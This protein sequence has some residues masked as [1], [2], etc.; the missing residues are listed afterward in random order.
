ML[1]IYV[2][3]CITV[4]LILCDSYLLLLLQHY[5]PVIFIFVE[6]AGQI[7]G[8]RDEST[9]PTYGCQVT[10]HSEQEKQMLKIYRKKRRG[11]GNVRNEEM[12]GIPGK[13]LLILTPKSWDCRGE[14]LSLSPLSLSLSLSLSPLSLSLSLSLSLRVQALLHISVWPVE[15][16]R[17]RK[18]DKLL[19]GAFA[20][21]IFS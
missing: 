7:K 11:R 1:D 19:S 4:Y 2:V 21:G 13:T 20:E 9:K 3:Y 18:L 17:E 8:M 6:I 14:H 16:E 12:K 10:I 15:R 5:C